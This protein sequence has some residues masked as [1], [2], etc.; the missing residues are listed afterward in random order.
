MVVQA[1]GQI[2]STIIA[3]GVAIKGTQ[4]IGESL[5]PRKKQK[6]LRTFKL[7]KRFF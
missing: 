6:K 3:G 2:T 4:I 1:I 7:D 5:K